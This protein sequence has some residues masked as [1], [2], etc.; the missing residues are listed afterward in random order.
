MFSTG[1]I[2]DLGF[3]AH[4]LSLSELTLEVC[5][6]SGFLMGEKLVVPRRRV[7]K[8]WYVGLSPDHADRSKNDVHDDSLIDLNTIAPLNNTYSIHGDLYIFFPFLGK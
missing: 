7:R 5:R 3:W 4:C 1:G 6:P 2:D 8:D